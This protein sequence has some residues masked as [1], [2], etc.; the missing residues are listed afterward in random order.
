M[1]CTG[2]LDWINQPTTL[3]NGHHFIA[4]IRFLYLYDVRLPFFMKVNSPTAILAQI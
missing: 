2:G 4:L 1:A 3:K